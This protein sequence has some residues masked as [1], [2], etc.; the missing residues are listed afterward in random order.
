MRI[1]VP[2]DDEKQIAAHTGRCKGFA[3]YSI[4]G[5]QSQKLE[6]RTFESAHS[7]GEHGR[8]GNSDGAHD[9]AHGHHGESGH[10]HHGL[11]E[12]VHDCDLFLAMGMGPRLV[13]D[14]QAHGIKIVFTLERDVVKAVEALAL[15]QLVENPSGS[16]CHRH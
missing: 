1:A 8:H 9:C 15:G 10:S 13:N 3:I 16:A 12:A 11:I 4:E 14:L 2:T 6:Y 5:E 7:S